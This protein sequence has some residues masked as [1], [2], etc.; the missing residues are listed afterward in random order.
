M[1]IT[2]LKAVSLWFWVSLFLLVS[3][4]WPC[5]LE[6]P[7]LFGFW[8]YMSL[9]L[10][11]PAFRAGAHRCIRA[12][13]RPA[14]ALH[15]WG[16]RVQLRDQSPRG[17]LLDLVVLQKGLRTPLQDVPGLCVGALQVLHQLQRGAHCHWEGAH[18]QRCPRCCLAFPARHGCP[19]QLVGIHSRSPSSSL[20][21]SRGDY[22]LCG[23]AFP[24]ENYSLKPIT[25]KWKIGARSS[26]VCTESQQFSLDLLFA[27]LWV[28]YLRNL[29]V[30]CHN[31]RFS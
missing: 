16:D 19:R 3:A 24:E 27:Y 12:G 11:L 14:P 31:A 15:R 30:S 7:I 6:L 17:V 18:W 2:L 9:F 28:A 8:Y 25:H 29:F 13:C 23:D 20:S 4:A 5:V 21:L 26:P 10:E 1:H 22:S